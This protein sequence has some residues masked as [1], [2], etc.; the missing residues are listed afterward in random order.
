MRV[1]VRRVRKYTPKG[2]TGETGPRVAG[3]A[4]ATEPRLVGRSGERQQ[5]VV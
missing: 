1:W 2:G 5:R 3:E 4:V